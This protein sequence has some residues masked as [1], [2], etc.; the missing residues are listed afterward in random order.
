MQCSSQLAIVRLRQRMWWVHTTEE[1]LLC[2]Q[3]RLQENVSQTI[4]AGQWVLWNITEQN[5]RLCRYHIRQNWKSQYIHIGK[6]SKRTLHEHT[7]RCYVLLQCKGTKLLR[8]HVP[9]QLT[10]TTKRRWTGL[11]EYSGDI[12]GRPDYGEVI[13]IIIIII[14]CNGN[15]DCVCFY[16]TEKCWPSKLC[17]CFYLI[18]G[19]RIPTI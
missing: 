6:Q 17:V 19:Y 5:V 4:L 16:L 3:V 7:P 10:Y 15:Q 12:K 14:I 8:R 18:M 11:T 1:T 13:I 9:L 2:L